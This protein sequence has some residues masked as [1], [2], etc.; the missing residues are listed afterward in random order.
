MFKLIAWSFVWLFALSLATIC[1]AQNP[2]ALATPAVE[3]IPLESRMNEIFSAESFDG[4]PYRFL[5]PTKLE[6]GKR[7]P[8]VL[9][10]HG[11]GE[12]GSDNLAQLKHVAGD[13]AR[14]DRRATYPAYVVIPQCPENQRW[15]ETPWDLKSG[16]NQFPDEP[17]PA[18]ASALALV[19]DR[20][21][22]FPI[23]PARMY[24]AGLSMGGQGAWFAAATPPKRFAAM[25]EVCGGGDPSW[26]DRYQGI[27]VWA[28]HGDA[29]PVVP[30]GRGREMIVALTHSGHHP[31]LRYTEYPGVGHD[32]WT[33][34][35]ARD[36]V[37]EWLMR[38]S[39]D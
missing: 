9:F 21:G 29:D 6:P 25:L 39:K 34:T 20:V 5:Q 36:D 26:A 15:V 19:D 28:F 16:L 23:D 18:M 1:P 24:V 33:Q 13:F 3:T 8:L 27:P 30:V 31:E 4:L 12:R 38:Q 22:R 37:F 35:F 2:A 7:Y 11:A 10:L 14:A 32:S 17:S